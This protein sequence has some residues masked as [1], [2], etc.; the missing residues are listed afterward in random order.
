MS[1]P[2]SA[3][4]LDV[5]SRQLT[6]MQAMLG[7]LAAHCE[8]KKIDPAAFL[9][10]RLYPDMFA[11]TRQVQIACDFAKVAGARLSGQ[12][13]PSHPDAETTIAE[14]QERCGKVIAYL[15][16]LDRAAVDAAG[17]RE[18]TFRTGPDSSATLPG[19]AYLTGFILPNF[20]FHLTVAYAI[21]RHNG[22]EI[23]KRDFMGI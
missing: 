21:L 6:A 3:A 19:G 2:L 7:K 22:L 13:P 23:G 14:L 20:Y 9:N 12:E 1:L 17:P 8:G 16:S 5:F 15:A 18:I 4:S 10:A 11:F